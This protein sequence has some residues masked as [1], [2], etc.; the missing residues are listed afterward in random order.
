MFKILSMYTAKPQALHSRLVGHK[1]IPEHNFIHME[2]KLHE[3]QGLR[4]S[5][6]LCSVG[7][8]LVTDISGPPIGPIFKGQAIEIRTEVLG[9]KHVNVTTSFYRV[10]HKSLRNFRTQ[11]CNNQERQG[12]KEHINR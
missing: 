5:G 11:L 8:F 6:M 7:L 1:Y 9:T 3:Y 4:S 2:T 12:R 10:I